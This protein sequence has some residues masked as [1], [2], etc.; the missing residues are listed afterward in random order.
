VSGSTI[1][2]ERV[3]VT[4]S[5]ER[6]LGVGRYACCGCGVLTPRPDE[7]ACK[8]F[9]VAHPGESYI[10]PFSGWWPHDWIKI[11]LDEGAR[12]LHA[13]G[14]CADKHVFRGMPV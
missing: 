5:T 4:L 11:V 14:P 7:A 13:C 10:W 9:A 1:D 3:V 8:S 2:R 6:S 12:E